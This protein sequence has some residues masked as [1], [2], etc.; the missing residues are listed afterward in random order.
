MK[1]AGLLMLAGVLVI[2]GAFLHR[3]AR[4]SPTITPSAVPRP[5][6]SSPANRVEPLPVLQ[7]PG[8]IPESGPRAFVMGQGTGRVLGTA[9]T[10]RRFRIA[11]ESNLA[12]ELDEFA[13]TVE[14]VLGDPRSWIAGR[15]VR[16]QRVAGGVPF[17]FTIYLVTRQTAYAMCKVN[18]VDIRQDGVPYTSCRQVKQVIINVDRWRLSVPEYV[19]RGIPLARYREYVVN[20]EVGHELG[21]GHETCP[22]PGKLAPTMLTQT[23]SLKG[24]VAN[25]WPYVDG[26]R[27]AGA[28]AP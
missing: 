2:M 8:D 21:H 13:T 27:Y 6:A 28:P 1:K 23:L 22:G 12:G 20:H 10:L 17:D 9:G 5:P 18:G 11:V 4:P 14:E 16:F 26:K 19:S 3:I 25:A 15:Q 7:L 24:C